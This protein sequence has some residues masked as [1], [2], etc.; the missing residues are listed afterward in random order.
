MNGDK[1]NLKEWLEIFLADS[2]FSD[3]SIEELVDL[4]QAAWEKGNWGDKRNIIF[5]LYDTPALVRETSLGDGIIEAWIVDILNEGKFQEEDLYDKFIGFLGR[6]NSTSEHLIGLVLLYLTRLLETYEK[7]INSY[8]IFIEFQKWV[9]KDDSPIRIKGSQIELGADVS[10]LQ[11]KLFDGYK[12]RVVEIDRHRLLSLSIGVLYNSANLNLFKINVA[13]IRE[14]WEH[15]Y[16][17]GSLFVPRKEDVFSDIVRNENI[18]DLQKIFSDEYLDDEDGDILRDDD[19]WHAIRLFL[20]VQAS[21]RYQET[22]KMLSG[23]VAK[24]LKSSRSIPFDIVEWMLFQGLW[25]DEEMDI[26]A[27]YELY[28]NSISNLGQHKEVSMLIGELHPGPDSIWGQL[29]AN[30]HRSDL[31]LFVLG[32]K[33]EKRN[34]GENYLSDEDVRALR[35]IQ[36]YSE[37]RAWASDIYELAEKNKWIAP[38]IKPEKHA[39]AP[40]SHATFPD[41][42]APHAL[43]EYESL[44]VEYLN[45]PASERTIKKIV[46]IVSKIR[47]LPRNHQFSSFLFWVEETKKHI[48]AGSHSNANASAELSDDRKPND[49]LK[50]YF[51]NLRIRFFDLL[52]WR[53]SA[54]KNAAPSFANSWM[55]EMPLEEEAWRSLV[56]LLA[57]Y[58]AR[59]KLGESISRKVCSAFSLSYISQAP[60]YFFLAVGVFL[61]QNNSLG[62]LIYED[63]EEVKNA[64]L[65]SLDL[66]PLALKDKLSK[67]LKKETRK[68]SKPETQI[69][70]QDIEGSGNY[71]ENKKVL[72]Y[73]VAVMAMISLL[74]SSLIT[75]VNNRDERIRATQTQQA[76]LVEQAQQAQ[77]TA[78]QQAQAVATQ[79][80]QATATQQAQEAVATEQAARATQEA[81]PIASVFAAQNWDPVSFLIYSRPIGEVGNYSVGYLNGN[82]ET[83]NFP[84]GPNGTECLSVDWPFLRFIE[85]GDGFMSQMNTSCKTSDG[86]YIWYAV[87]EAGP[88]GYKP[89]AP[90]RLENYLNR[91][92]FETS[93]IRWSLD[94]QFGLW[95]YQVTPDRKSIH[96]FSSSSYALLDGKLDVIALDPANFTNEL[97]EILAFDWV[98]LLDIEAN[99][100][101]GRFVVA[102]SVAGEINIYEAWVGYSSDNK[103]VIYQTKR[104]QSVDF[105]EIYDLD[106]SS[107]GSQLVIVGADKDSFEKLMRIYSLSENTDAGEPRLDL[108]Q[109]YRPNID[110]G[111]FDEITQVSWSPE[112]VDPLRIAVAGKVMDNTST[113]LYCGKGCLF[114]V[115][116]DTLKVEQ[117]V[118]WTLIENIQSGIEHFWWTKALQ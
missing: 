83:F 71:F 50:K 44:M 112:G 17:G 38:P 116:L 41:H 84:S 73:F 61:L 15:E 64:R 2:E 87:L 18:S 8:K 99:R 70:K 60:D 105:S 88:D 68:P 85:Q 115:D 95:A 56:T 23:F 104:I 113:G 80:A 27:Q 12:Y 45:L 6:I 106:V 35:D 74:I 51:E 7:K 42:H 76:Q 9:Q 30:L 11:K 118:R 59:S 3:L 54:E 62:S 43:R 21:T 103:P 22:Q 92:L 49:S 16:H 25:L 48:H 110:L 111:F 47:G 29:E 81:P 5:F 32:N 36:N 28:K 4:F 33:L 102:I 63:Q 90:A 86:P 98:R 52:H 93:R 97:P 78:I 57:D 10:R 108:A 100:N 96:L 69:K 39:S 82:N 46:S 26:G 72:L 91:E 55:R 58:P 94:G 14:V 34:R 75:Q 109:A 1:K 79:Q 101:K 67:Y 89:V 65:V 37:Y 13:D 24:R 19:I 117:E 20:P 77:A 53:Q 107:D 66:L 40:A 114:V 31:F